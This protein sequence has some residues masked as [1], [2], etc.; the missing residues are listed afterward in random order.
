MKKVNEYL[1]KL[2]DSIDSSEDNLIV[3][4]HNNISDDKFDSKQLKMGIE[5]EYEHTDD[6]KI[7]KAIA[8]DHLAECSD[9]YTRLKKMEDECKR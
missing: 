9:Y 6:P 4:K 8:K 3:G 1:N 5:V 2:N 7:A